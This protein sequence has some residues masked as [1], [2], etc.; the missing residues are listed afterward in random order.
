M[1]GGGICFWNPSSWMCSKPSFF[2]N[3]FF[4]A[5]PCLKWKPC[6]YACVTPDDQ[7]T[8]LCGSFPKVSTP[9]PLFFGRL[10]TCTSLAS[11]GLWIKI[12]IFTRYIY[13]HS[14]I[15]L[16]SWIVKNLVFSGESTQ[17]LLICVDLLHRTL[18]RLWITG[19]LSHWRN[20]SSAAAAVAL[21]L[22]LWEAAEMWKKR[23][24][25]DHVLRET[26]DFPHFWV[27]FPRGNHPNLEGSSTMTTTH[28]TKL[29]FVMRQNEKFIRDLDGGHSQWKMIGWACINSHWDN[30]KSDMVYIDFQYHQMVHSL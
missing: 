12:P 15:C 19:P 6:Q 4:V 5:L 27:C 16:D 29:R 11:S 30:C 21:D 18:T 2:R 9:K 3:L 25:I 24:L 17:N 22:D 23:P 20:S 8:S 13:I 10:V 28:D 14:W 1:E 7:T 26:T